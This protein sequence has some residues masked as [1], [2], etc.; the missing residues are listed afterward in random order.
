MSISSRRI[1]KLP[2]ALRYRIGARIASTVRRWLVLA[3][4]R[5]CRVEFQ[6]PVF[7]GP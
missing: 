4:H 7:L 6:G 1:R 2:W 3:T 5:H